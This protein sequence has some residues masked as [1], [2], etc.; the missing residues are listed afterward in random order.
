MQLELFPF[1]DFC[2]PSSSYDGRLL[3]FVRT[4]V[5]LRIYGFS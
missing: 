5:W 3:Y 1:V 4:G 2:V